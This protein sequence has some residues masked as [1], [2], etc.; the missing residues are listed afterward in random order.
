MGTSNVV[1]NMSTRSRLFTG[2]IRD[3]AKLK[4]SHC[5]FPGCTIPATYSEV[6]HMAEWVRHRGRTSTD[7]AAILCGKHNRIKFRQYRLRRDRHG[8]AHFQRLDGTW[9]TPAG[10]EPPKEADLLPLHSQVR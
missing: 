8:Q 2:A 3:A 1:A 7:N 6:D 9:L 5:E 10:C 4:A